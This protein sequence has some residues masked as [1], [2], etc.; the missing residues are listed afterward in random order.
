MRNA[1]MS[2]LASL[3]A[4]TRIRL[5]AT[6][7]GAADYAVNALILFGFAAAGAVPYAVALKMAAVAVLFNAIFFG[8]IGF[9]LTQRFQDPSMMATQVI[10]GCG[11]NLFGLFLAPQIAY[12]FIVNLF[13]P[14]CYGSLHLSQRALLRVWLILSGSLGAILW[15]AGAQ[16][17]IAPATIA[18]SGL[19]WLLVTVA[20]GRFLA[21]NAEVSRLRLRL[22]GKNKH[23]AAVSA[24]L[25]DLASR[26]DLTGLWNRREFVR[27]LLNERKRAERQGGKLCIAILNADHFKQINDRFGHLVGD[28][29][30]K[31]LAK[32]LEKTRRTTDNLARY[33]G[34]EFTL[35]LLDATLDAAIVALERMRT[36]VEQHNWE[37][38]APGLQKMTI[39]AGV[40][41]WQP[42]ETDGQVINRADRAMYEAKSAG[43]NCVHVA[44]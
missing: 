37:R 28:Q 5:R 27:T 42:G 15:L 24:R 13:G 34:E 10:A 35:L 39:S 1:I 4:K 18:E 26:D 25:A 11:I 29:V 19:F 33:G 20:V 8:A 40:A 32:V 41:A 14:L 3:D 7:F 2:W 9:R 43:R 30:L 21:I 31:E 38:I 16:V 12:M 17:G 36:S 23:L 22:Q 6:A 44:Q